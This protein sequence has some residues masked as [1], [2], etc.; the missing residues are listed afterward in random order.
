M[1]QHKG[2]RERTIHRALGVMAAMA[3]PAIVQDGPSS[4]TRRAVLAETAAVSIQ[5]SLSKVRG[6]DGRMRRVDRADASNQARS[7]RQAAAAALNPHLLT[8]ASK[9]KL[10]QAEDLPAELRFMRGAELP[11]QHQ[12]FVRQLDLNDLEWMVRSDSR[13]RYQQC[14]LFARKQHLH[15][16]FDV[17]VSQMVECARGAL[18]H[19]SWAGVACPKCGATLA[20]HNIH[21]HTLNRYSPSNFLNP[22]VDE[23]EP[24]G[25]YTVLL[26]RVTARA[27][28]GGT[29]RVQRP[30]STLPPKAARTGVVE[31]RWWDAH[32][33]EVPLTEAWDGVWF[34]GALLLHGVSPVRSGT[35]LSLA[36]TLACPAQVE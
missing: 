15:R 5:R 14:T 1:A 24:V 16:C 33:V 30:G 11:P 4:A 36:T 23:D 34:D 13:G 25:R 19:L 6:A 31:G 22:H 29:L 28:V 27:W 20:E 3:E 35:R 9:A 8:R 18:L 10:W 21:E 2:S 32:S 17:V 7:A 12:E 26:H